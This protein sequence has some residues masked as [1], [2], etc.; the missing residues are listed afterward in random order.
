MRKPN[1]LFVHCHDLGRYL[2]C[3]G[4]DT[5]QSPNLDRLAGEGVLLERMFCT[6]PQCSPSRASLFTGRY[7]HTNGVMGL[8][9]AEFAWDLHPEERHLGEILRD[10]GYRTAAVGV[11][12]E[13]RSGAARCGYGDHRPQ[14]RAEQAVDNAIAR[15]GELAASDEAPFCL[16]VGFLEPHRLP[17]PDPN[18]DMGFVAPGIEPDAALGV[19]VP[20]YL[21][22]TDGTKTE[23]AELQGAVRHMDTHFG[24]LMAAVDEL[25]LRDTTLVVFTTDHGVAMPRAKC[26]LYDPGL[27]V[28][29]IFRM[30]MRE[31]WR[32][33]IRHD[34]LLSNIDVLPTL[35]ELLDIAAPEGVQGRSFLGLMDG[36]A[37]TRRSEIHGEITYHDYYDPR[38]C[39]RTD[40]HKL[41]ANFSAAPAYMDPS[42]SWRPRSDTVEPRNRATAYHP[43]IELFDLR[44]DPWE[45]RDLGDDP[46]HAELRA[47]LMGR[48]YAHM[49]DTQDPLLDGAVT[50]PMHT[51][52]VDL[53]QQAGG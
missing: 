29:T 13:T 36:G 21:E 5:V 16:S 46:A 37:Y 40:T 32:G 1:V 49:R 41:I 9:H 10:A 48:L 25:G 44:E 28:A 8:T 53:L 3:Y 26:S 39:I 43:K 15:L 23:L 52:V 51:A 33:G 35:L 27:G 14:P 4:V 11:I 6:A 47:E 45:L 30:P 18:A 7:P 20:D 2:H 17:Q 24:R 50:S 22:P 34:A 19:Q 42:Q 38:R 12:H 31:G